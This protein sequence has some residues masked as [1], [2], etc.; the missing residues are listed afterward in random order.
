MIQVMVW[1]HATFALSDGA[2]ILFAY[3]E[4]VLAGWIDVVAKADPNAPKGTAELGVIEQSPSYHLD[5]VRQANRGGVHSVGCPVE[6]FW[7]NRG[8]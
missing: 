5:A 1:G 2:S 7:T 3:H 6:E 4:E 8:P